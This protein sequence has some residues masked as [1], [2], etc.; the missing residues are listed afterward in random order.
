VLCNTY[1]LVCFL[2]SAVHTHVSLATLK[3]VAFLQLPSLE[4]IFSATWIALILALKINVLR[5][6]TFNFTV[7]GTT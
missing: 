3:I 6:I 5:E 1:K 7:V 4:L 2:Y